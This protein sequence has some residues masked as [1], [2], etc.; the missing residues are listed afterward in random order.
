MLLWGQYNGGALSPFTFQNGGAADFASI[1]RYGY[2][3]E[4]VTNRWFADITGEWAQSA[5][6]NNVSIFG[7]V[8]QLMAKLTSY[9]EPTALMARTVTTFPLR[10]EYYSWL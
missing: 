7:I 6:S 1:V 9:Y 8:S 4:S 3:P 10:P 2:R 5:Q